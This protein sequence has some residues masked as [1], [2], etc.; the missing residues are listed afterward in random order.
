MRWPVRRLK[1]KHIRTRPYRPQT[2]GRKVS[3]SPVK[4]LF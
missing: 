2:N 4:P 3:P 1:L